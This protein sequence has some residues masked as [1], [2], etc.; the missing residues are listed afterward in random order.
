M[1]IIQG[2]VTLPDCLHTI[3]TNIPN[4]IKKTILPELTPIPENAFV[5]G[6]II[7]DSITVSGKSE[8]GEFIISVRYVELAMSILDAKFG[9]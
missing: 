1:V 2:I 5:I 4:I 7:P 3:I 8:V 9:L 6:C